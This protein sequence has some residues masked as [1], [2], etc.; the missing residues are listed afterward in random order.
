[1]K[2]HA[3]MK[4]KS[5]LAFLNKTL[6]VIVFFPFSK[7]IILKSKVSWRKLECRCFTN[8]AIWSSNVKRM[9]DNEEKVQYL[10]ECNKVQSQKPLERT[11]LFQFLI[12]TIDEQFLWLWDD[13]KKVT[14]ASSFLH[15]QSFL[16]QLIQPLGASSREKRNLIKSFWYFIW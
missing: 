10:G 4:E 15:F 13:N 1:M 2:N 6:I 7:L 12:L 8:R 11:D 9:G 5:C 16:P 3:L 14:L